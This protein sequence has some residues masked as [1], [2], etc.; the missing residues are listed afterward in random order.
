MHTV[1]R[2]HHLLL[3]LGILL[4]VGSVASSKAEV[5]I[6]R[7]TFSAKSAL[8]PRLSPRG[9]SEVLRGY[10]IYDLANP[11]TSKTVDI[12]TGRTIA[13]ND[14]LWYWITP[15]HLILAPY[16]R[17]NDTVPETELALLGEANNSYCQSRIY[18]G[19]ISRI[20]FRLNGLTFFN[21]ARVLR[22]F[23]TTT[24]IDYDHFR[25][26]NVL[27]IDPLTGNAP[28]DVDAGVAMVVA[29]LVDLGYSFPSP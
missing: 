18:R 27:R 6:Y 22:G 26:S 23:G 5:R 13:I 3:I 16:D 11:A 17:N 2:H 4:M 7:T 10:L 14:E 28:A 20:G 9:N 1:N 24:S 12:L 29:K 21:S 19:H 25:T 15:N 8:F